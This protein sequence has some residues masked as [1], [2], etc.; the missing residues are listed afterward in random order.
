MSMVPMVFRDWWDDFERPTSRLWDH[1][2][3][4]GMRRDDMMRS[5]SYLRPWRRGPPVSSTVV[6]ETSADNNTFSAVLDVGQ[7]S[8]AELSV[9]VSDLK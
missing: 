1:N 2:F 3:G 9:K 4:L 7:F 6:S 8:P 5:G